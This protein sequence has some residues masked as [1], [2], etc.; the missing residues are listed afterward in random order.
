[1]KKIIISLLL[2]LCLVSVTEAKQNSEKEA[3]IK[4][5][6]HLG[7]VLNDTVKEL[8]TL[9]KKV[10]EE[11]DTQHDRI[12]EMHKT[13][14]ELKKQSASPE[15]DP[16]LL[17]QGTAKMDS[18][19]YGTEDLT[20]DYAKKEWKCEPVSYKQDCTPGTG[21]EEIDLAG[22]NSY[23][24]QIDNFK[25]VDAGW[26]ICNGTEK[27]T[28]VA[29]MFTNVADSSKTYQVKS[30]FCAGEPP[31]QRKEQPCGSNGANS[32][33]KC[34]AFYPGFSYS[35]AGYCYKSIGGISNF[36]AYPS[37]AGDI[38]W[39]WASTSAG[40]SA[41]SIRPGIGPK[42]I[43]STTK[44]NYTVFEGGATNH[45]CKRLQNIAE[46]T[47][48]NK[49]NIKSFKLT[50]V[51]QDDYA[52][53]ELNKVRVFDAPFN[54]GKIKSL[55][56][57]FGIEVLKPLMQEKGDRTL[58]YRCENYRGRGTYYPN[59]ELKHLLVNGTNEI[60]VSVVVGNSGQIKVNTSIQLYNTTCP[61]GTTKSGDFCIAPLPTC[62][63]R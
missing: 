54:Y 50:S 51:T 5:R 6:Q 59:K 48:S 61:A 37:I 33:C 46:F 22:G 18:C 53:V 49:S 1:M 20:W 16:T 24:K 31:I 21:E 47:V 29:C 8:K 19:T 11:L 3:I 13:A 44:P 36:R 60:K 45:A 14:E 25:N 9:F 40:I 56:N 55:T 12:S 17:K 15:I 42:Y 38:R 10:D 23:C 63:M 34:S 4:T 35:P 26:G 28:Q 30:N 62:N 27:H 43:H 58:M 2:I 52:W 32:S 39:D 41:V 7:K 57:L